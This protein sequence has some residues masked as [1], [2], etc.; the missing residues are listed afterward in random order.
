[1]CNILFLPKNIPIKED[2]IRNM[3]LNNPDGFGMLFKDTDG[4][5]KQVAREFYPEG[6][7]PNRVI[8]MLKKFKQ[9]DRLVHVRYNTVGESS[10]AN[11]HPFEV[12]NSKKRTV[13]MMHNGTMYDYKPQDQTKSDSR[14][15]SEIFL[16]PLL[17][18]HTV[19]GDYFKGVIP[20]IIDKFSSLQSKIVL[21][22]SHLEPLFIGPW[23]HEKNTDGTYH[24]STSNNDYFG[25]INRSRSVEARKASSTNFSGASGYQNPGA[26]VGGRS[27]VW[28]STLQKF[29]E[30]TDRKFLDNDMAGEVGKSA[31]G[32]FPRNRRVV[33]STSDNGSNLRSSS[34][35]LVNRGPSIPFKFK[36][37]LNEINLQRR[38]IKEMISE[39]LGTIGKSLDDMDAQSLFSTEGYDML[40]HV[41]NAEWTEV[42]KKHPDSVAGLM[43]LLAYGCSDLE[44][45]LGIEQ[46]KSA[47]Q[48]EIIDKTA[49]ELAKYN[50]KVQDVAA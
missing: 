25:S 43:T 16:T 42:V 8:H 1:M 3:V 20:K 36:V 34:A 27:T 21:W 10:L 24:Y 23:I 40:M 49:V 41:T 14:F 29:E 35:S 6:T 18:E 50:V 17:K 28:N 47:K 33:L 39:I 26:R 15:F 38:T 31:E 7:D 11:T 32:F 48:Q 22:G 46:R 5:V 44:T 13:Y 37:A 9:Y 19:Q 30:N 2:A 45:S 12:F 4:T